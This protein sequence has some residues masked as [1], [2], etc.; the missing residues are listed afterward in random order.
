MI[1]LLMNAHCDVYPDIKQQW[2]HDDSFFF[3][4]HV[5]VLMDLIWG[6]CSY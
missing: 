1:D 5:Y 4:E 2:C 6:H 3:S